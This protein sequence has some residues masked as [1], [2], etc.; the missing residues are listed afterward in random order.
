MNARDKLDLIEKIRSRI[1]DN[2][3]IKDAD[4][5]EEIARRWVKFGN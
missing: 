5:A 4:Y 2:T 1:L 3:S